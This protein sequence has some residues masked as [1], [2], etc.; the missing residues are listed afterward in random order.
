MEF[1][2]EKKIQER[3]LLRFI[4]MTINW[5]LQYQILLS[6]P[7]VV[8]A[9][10]PPYVVNN[11]LYKILP[12]GIA[13]PLTPDFPPEKNTIYCHACFILAIIAGGY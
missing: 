7:S 12:V 9:S 1:A 3:L 5:W 13:N 8:L 4:Q 2:S 6:L 11:Q 10:S